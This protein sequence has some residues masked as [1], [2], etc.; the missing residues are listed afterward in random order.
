[1]EAFIKRSAT[2]GRAVACKKGCS[3]CC[4][5]KVYAVTHEFMY[6]RDHVLQHMDK[7]TVRNMELRAQK[8]TPCLFLESGTCSIYK[9]RPMAC[10]IYVSSSAIACEKALE[11]SHSGDTFPDL[12]EFPL[13]AG[14]MLNQGF[15]AYLKQT[16]FV[17]TE[18][19]LNEGYL[20]MKTLGQNMD[21]WINGTTASK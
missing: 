2:E 15:V 9:Y 17:V 6:L 1:M 8:Q 3:W 13:R 5:Q 18:V 11:E 19:P 4:H 21:G 12:F 10:R 16:R 20:S 14:H 7:T